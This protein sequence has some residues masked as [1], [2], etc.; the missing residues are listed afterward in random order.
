M[1][2]IPVTIRFSVIKE[3]F[4][5]ALQ[6]LRLGLRD[7]QRDARDF[8]Q[9]I[10]SEM[11]AAGVS[12]SQFNE[13]SRSIGESLDYS[14]E[15]VSAGLDEINDRISKYKQYLKDIG[16]LSP[17]RQAMLKEDG[18]V[19]AVGRFID[20][21]EAQREKYLEVSAAYDSLVNKYD[22]SVRSHTTLKAHLQMVRGEMEQMIAAAVESG[23]TVSA[24]AIRSSQA[25]KDLQDDA[26]R[27]AEA[28]N[29]INKAGSGESGPVLF[30]ATEDDYNHAKE[31]TAQIDELTRKL[32]TASGDNEITDINAQ[33]I[34]LQDELD[35]CNQKASE[36]ASAL[37]GRLGG[38]AA[39]SS[40]RLY[41]LNA[42]LE[43][44]WKTYDELNEKLDDTGEKMRVASEAGDIESLKALQ[45][46]YRNLSAQVQQAGYAIDQTQARQNDAESAWGSLQAVIDGTNGSIG[47][48]VSG[49]RGLAMAVKGGSNPLQIFRASLS[50]VSGAAKISAASIKALWK[51][52]VSNPL[53]LILAAGAA[54]I[55]LLVKV[56]SSI[57]SAAEKQITLNKL[58]A[59]HLELLQQINSYKTSKIDD[60]VKA[61]ERELAIAKSQN[62]SLA[63]Q[64]HIEDELY[65][66]KSRRANYN[67]GFYG[68]EAASIEENRKK[69]LQYEEQL[70]KAKNAKAQ[71]EKKVEVDLQL[72]G[73]IS[74]QKVDK[75]IE[76]LQSLV[77][78]TK[79]KIEVGMKVRDE[80]EDLKAE[81]ARIAAERRQNAINAANAERAAIRETESVRISLTKDSYERETEAAKAATK[82]KIEDLKIR[83]AQDKNLTAKA[84]QSINEQIKLQQRK[85]NEDLQ[86]LERQH[87]QKLV[88]IRRQVEDESI[89]S[90][91]RTARQQQEDLRREYSRKMEDLTAEIDGG[92]AD[93]TLSKDEIDE[94][95]KLLAVYRNRYYDEL[96]ILEGELEQRRLGIA[97]EGIGLRLAAAR[98]GTAEELKLRLEALEAERRAEIEANRGKADDERQDEG[99][100]NAKYGRQR[101]ETVIGDYVSF[102]RQMTDLTETYELRRAELERRIAAEKDPKRQRELRRSISAL[103]KTYRQGLKELQQAFIKDGIGDVFVEATYE[104]VKEAVKK[105]TEMEGFKTAAEFNARYGTNITD[106]EF[107]AF[108]DNIRRV[109][110]EVQSLGKGGYT[111]RDAFKEA[112][113]GK[114]R[115]DIEKGTEYLVAG[116]QKIGSI[117]GG[118]ASAM[119]DFADAT[120]NA[121]LE[122]MAD[123]F[124]DIADTIST[125]GSYAAAGAQV[126]GGWGAVIGAVLGIGQGIVT[127]IFKSR[128]QDAAEREEAAKE[129]EEYTR[130]SAE[131]VASILSV[132]QSL[133]DTVSS[134]DYKNYHDALFGLMRELQ[135]DIRRFQEG[136]DGSTAWGALRDYAL[137]QG[138]GYYGTIG[139]W[140][141]GN[142]RGILSDEEIQR[143]LDEAY[144]GAGVGQG[145]F[146]GF[147][148]SLG[149]WLTGNGW[150]DSTFNTEEYNKLVAEGFANVVNGKIYSHMLDQQRLLERLNELYRDNSYN[151]VD[152]FNAQY[153]V[154]ADQKEYLEWY[155]ELLKAL[156]QDTTELEN[157]LAEV[158]HNMNTAV[159]EMFEGL[160]GSDL[161]GIV[162]K[163]LDIFKEFGDNFEA[164]IDKI[165]ESIND[166][167][168]NMVVQT[169]FVQPL[170]QRINK[171][172]KDYADSAGLVQDEDGNYIWTNEAFRG[173]A[174]GLRTLI[175]GENGALSMY[176]ELMSELNAA[177]LGW[178]D[179]AN[180]RSASSRG[181][182]TASQDSVDELNG[183][184]TAVQGHT[185]LINENTQ[186][187]RDNVTAIMGSVQRIEDYTQHLIRMDNDLHSLRST[188]EGIASPSGIRIRG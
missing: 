140:I 153:Q 174:E 157:Q 82:S 183:R 98:E 162:N 164:A 166:M 188:I 113:S 62:K 118:L 48:A 25:Y 3:Q 31:L 89:T 38:Q 66:L 101:L 87:Q 12:L 178:G 4:D 123:T 111:L 187:I 59:T 155:I 84:R 105:L 52:L 13:A 56:V 126:G 97:R 72:N 28:I 8:G 141:W 32:V 136:S 83:L 125:A 60:A 106:A 151:A 159:I 9:R 130:Q 92:K 173:M 29:E 109:K 36:A 21:L 120:K 149:S 26:R 67:L 144:G 42:L 18:T 156:G 107:D 75:A 116:F 23:D 135:N 68:A 165:N 103:E 117:V 24:N 34:T 86:R 51:T 64:Y 16:Q 133:L 14:F 73:K 22:S 74:R 76:A 150:Q 6:D 43:E 2:S 50:A 53:G 81:A 10:D 145:G 39:E 172:L 119:R 54:V 33:I 115:E 71:D 110:K 169:V 108:V 41:E 171:Y 168:R 5:D 1:D 167:I 63:E 129:G 100:I 61:K 20:K 46:E 79:K 17:S 27:T 77:D 35:D 102:Q 179:T 163:W 147:I 93:G 44:Q 80:A 90:A 175:D 37:G 30:F 182:A 58:E 121:E 104:N 128:A 181:I 15:G 88:A 134:L 124:Q 57:Q 99:A 78:N 69:L 122:R 152:Y 185:F 161:Q 95:M 148:N 143:I 19:D 176:R 180:S 94:K 184:M 49:F 160:A 47:G 85:L 170:M 96:V 146:A 154:Y 112:F 177:G 186:I 137:N 131:N 114:T 11:N 142:T 127:A 139:D 7:L 158:S 138:G 70:A 40:V 65:N 91:P 132:V 45:E 55:A